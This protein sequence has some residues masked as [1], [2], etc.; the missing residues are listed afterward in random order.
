MKAWLQK[1]KTF[2]STKPQCF[3]IQKKRVLRLISVALTFVILNLTVGC[4]N[5]FEVK[6]SSKPS[7]ETIYGMNDS[8]KTI[9]V[10]FNEKKWLLT[11]IQL[12]NNIIEGQLNEYKF[13]PTLKPVN[14]VKA[15]RYLSRSDKTKDQKYLLKEVHLYLDQFADTGNS[16]V[17]IPVSSI[18]KIEIYDKDSGSTVGSW[19]LGAV[20]VTAGAFAVALVAVLIFKES[21]PFIYTW[22]G[23]KYQFAGEIYSGTIH[24]PLERND[25]LKL[26]AYP[27]QKSYTLKITNEVREIQNTNMLELLVIDHPENVNILMDKYGKVI[28]LN[29]TAAPSS[30]TNLAGENVTALVSS[31]DNLFYQSVSSGPDIPLKDGVILTFPGQADAKIARV[32]IHAKNSI[33]LDYMMGQFHDM[34]GTAY[35]RYMKN[36]QSAPSNEMRQW[37]LDQGIPLS[38]YIERDGKWDFVDYYNIAGPMK[39]KDDV[40]SIALKGNETNPLKVKLEFG[41]FLWEIDYAAID[42]SVDQNVTSY[43]ASVK[44]ALTA[45]KKD[46]VGLLNKDDSH[47]YT[48]PSVGDEAV[49]TFDLPEPPA[50]GLNRTMILHSKGWYALLL[51]PVGKPDI[52]K[53]KAFRQPGHFNLFIAEKLNEIKQWVSPV[54]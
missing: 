39:Y 37:S 12:K 44:T 46:V 8:G 17:S 21:C 2:W 15:N 6:S 22:D 50:A 38:L 25:Y 1:S 23:E 10:H 16:M 32:A 54:Q 48:Q 4:H 7:I 11:R 51:N 9:V 41:S 35:K 24:K 36:Q 33:I 34:F 53:L 30:A 5:Y 49:V 31:K 19:V 43:I 14:P 13:P 47:Y 40:L 52:E 45:E 42:Y 18:T 3:K 28:T 27:G 29:Q 26:P 20:G